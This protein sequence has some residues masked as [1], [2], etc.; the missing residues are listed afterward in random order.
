M[1]RYVT[2]VQTPW[3]SERAFTYLSDLGH[4]ADWDPG[5]KSSQPVANT[6]P[7]LGAAWDVGRD[8]ARRRSRNHVA[9]RDHR[10]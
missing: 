3:S 10:N 7:G 5:V 8:S 9:L 2:S 1:A 6:G 4:F